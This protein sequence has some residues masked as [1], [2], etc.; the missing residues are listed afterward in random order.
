MTVQINSRPQQWRGKGYSKG[1]KKD[2]RKQE[3]EHNRNTEGG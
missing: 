1:E 3:K 2:Q